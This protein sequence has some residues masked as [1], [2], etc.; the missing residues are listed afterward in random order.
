MNLV[1]WAVVA[2]ALIALVCSEWHKQGCAWQ[3]LA[4]GAAWY[5]ILCGGLCFAVD[6]MLKERENG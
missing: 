2:L 6:G 5:S 1:I 4:M 3:S